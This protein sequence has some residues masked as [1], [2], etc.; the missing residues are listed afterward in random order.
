MATDER[1]FDS[2]VTGTMPGASTPVQTERFEVSASRPMRVIMPATNMPAADAEPLAS[3]A[4]AEQ[5]RNN[6]V[7]AQMLA[8]LAGA[9]TAA[10]VGWLLIG[11]RRTIR[12]RQT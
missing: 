1:K 2:D 7:T 12:S 6:S 9:I 11:P 5:P 10:I 4:I 3:P 8:T